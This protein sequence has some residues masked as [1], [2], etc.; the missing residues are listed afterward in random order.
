MSG[1]RNLYAMDQFLVTLGFALMLLGVVIAIL[2]TLAFAARS[3]RA[4]GGA[5]VLVGPFPII[6][7]SSS[8]AALVAAAIALAMM[9]LLVLLLLGGVCVA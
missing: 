7:G 2:A 1:R 6:V 8:R 9:G 3:A 5:V 4:E